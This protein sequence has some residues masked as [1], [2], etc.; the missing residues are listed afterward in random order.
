MGDFLE[1]SLKE[2]REKT[3]YDGDAGGIPSSRR[4]RVEMPEW[5]LGKSF[6]VVLEDF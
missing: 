2:F 6:K 5:N 1:E 3:L 4:I